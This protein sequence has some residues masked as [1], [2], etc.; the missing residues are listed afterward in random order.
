M[1]THNLHDELMRAL[2]VDALTKAATATLTIEELLENLR[3]NAEHAST[4]INL[5]LP[6]ACEALKGAFNIITCSDAAV[7]TVVCTEGF[8]AGNVTVT[9]A[10]GEFIIIYADA[11][12]WY[13]LHNE[14]SA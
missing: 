5:T 7:V 12:D 4:Q 9:L 13:V 8:G 14:P 6:A 3:I 10:Q 11:D 1:S 2:A